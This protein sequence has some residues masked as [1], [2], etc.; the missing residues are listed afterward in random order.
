[1]ALSKQGVE[2]IPQ[3]LNEADN[4]PFEDGRWAPPV[5]TVIESPYADLDDYCYHGIQGT[6]YNNRGKLSHNK[7][8]K[9]RS[10]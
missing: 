6:S 8:Q 2:I 1:M 10:N 7:R 5:E 4:I 3:L 9:T